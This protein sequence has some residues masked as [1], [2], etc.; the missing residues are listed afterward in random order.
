MKPLADR[1]HR[2]EL[3]S[4][5]SIFNV[6]ERLYAALVVTDGIIR[7]HRRGNT[8]QRTDTFL[9]LV[10]KTRKSP[11]PIAYTL[12]SKLFILYKKKV[13]FIV[14]G[15]V[16]KYKFMLYTWLYWAIY[17]FYQN[18]GEQWNFFANV[19]IASWHCGESKIYFFIREENTI[20]KL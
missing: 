18:V 6:A 11:T 9:S 14:V 15:C 13:S 2:N 19:R 16:R 17:I 1:I 3:G 12:Y 4:V 10:S 7:Y 5:N 8:R 20:V